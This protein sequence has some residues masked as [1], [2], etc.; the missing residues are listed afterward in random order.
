[1]TKSQVIIIKSRQQELLAERNILT[2]GEKVKLKK[3]RA[4][5]GCSNS[6]MFVLFYQQY[7][8]VYCEDYKGEND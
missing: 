8:A 1:M 6:L 3:T 7:K 4:G 5:K 2:P